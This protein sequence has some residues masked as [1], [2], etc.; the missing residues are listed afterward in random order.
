MQAVV[1]DTRRKTLTGRTPAATVVV[2]DV[3]KLYPTKNVHPAL[4]GIKQKTLPE[5]NRTYITDILPF[6]LVRYQY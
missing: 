4:A 3:L 1:F 2:L 5:W 6:Y